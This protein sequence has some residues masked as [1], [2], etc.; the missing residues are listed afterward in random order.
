M[1]LSTITPP[2]SEVVDSSDTVLRQW[3]RLEADETEQDELID[4]LAVAAQAKVEAF[5]RRRLVTQTVR[6][7]LD[8]FCDSGVELPIAPVASVDQVQYLNDAGAWTTLASSAYQLI[9][10][11]VPNELH[12]AYGQIWPVPREDA[13]VVRID[14]VVGYGDAADVP[15]PFQQAIRRLTSHFYYHRDQVEDSLPGSI[16]DLLMPHVFWV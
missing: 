13:A 8:G 10:S 7:L 15:E 6:L 5:T 12:P 14:L 3:L 9:A 11:R 1:A 16:R 4:D 2:A